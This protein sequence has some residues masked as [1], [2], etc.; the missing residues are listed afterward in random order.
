M[1]IELKIPL[2]HSVL[3]FVFFAL[4][5][6]LGEIEQQKGDKKPPSGGQEHGRFMWSPVI[7]VSFDEVSGQTPLIEL[8]KTF[9]RQSFYLEESSIY[10]DN[11][12]RHIESWPTPIKR[13]TLRLSSSSE[14]CYQVVSAIDGSDSELAKPFA[15]DVCLDCLWRTSVIQGAGLLVLEGVSAEL[16]AIRLGRVDC[17]TFSSLQG[18]GPV[19]VEHLL[20][21]SPLNPGVALRLVLS[22]ALDAEQ[23]LELVAFELGIYIDLTGIETISDSH[24]LLQHSVGKVLLEEL[25]EPLPSRADG[26]IDVVIGPCIEREN[27]FGTQRLAGLTPRIPGGAGLADAVFVARRTCGFRDQ[28]SDDLEEIARLVAHELGHYLGLHHPEELDGSLDDL[29]STGIK[30]LMHREPLRADSI[31]LSGEQRS[32]MLAHPFV[33]DFKS[34]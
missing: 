29:V 32:R 22:H 15:Q 5:A 3:W 6:C 18:G 11:Q 30:N 20:T 28:E 1:K 12:L 8:P 26:V 4:S 34:K 17:E 7:E 2:K 19:V 24:I 21:Q 10:K 16:V 25:L 27:A 14:L 23:L 31:G 33:S 9:H 13:Q